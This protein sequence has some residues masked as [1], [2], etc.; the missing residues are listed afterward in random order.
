MEFVSQPAKLLRIASM[1]REVLQDVRQSSVDEPGRK[2][3]REI[4]D[5]AVGELKEGLSEDLQHEL[6]TLTIPLEGTPSE[7]EIRIAQAQLVGWLEGLFQGIQAALW[8]QH[9]QA[10]AQFDE[11]RR[12]G[13][14]PGSPEQQSGDREPGQYL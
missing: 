14:P 7:S 5:R 9:M 6:G 11:M 13:L 2:R 1:I 4:Y 3:L 12:R 8:A 10:R